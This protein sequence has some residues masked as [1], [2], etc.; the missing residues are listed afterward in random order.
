[1]PKELIKSLRIEVFLTAKEKE[2]IRKMAKIHN[3][4]MSQFL[5]ESA[6]SISQN[7]PQNDSMDD[8]LALMEKHF[9]DVRNFQLQQQVTMFIM[10]QFIM[11]LTNKNESREDILE[12]YDEQYEAALKQFKKESDGK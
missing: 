1:M 7:K 10:M 12:F 2:E 11:W 6:L 8:M 4:T 9:S 5:L 3:K